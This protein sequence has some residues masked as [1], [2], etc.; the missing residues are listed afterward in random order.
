MHSKFYNLIIW[1]LEF[2]TEYGFFEKVK[3]I[4]G[5]HGTN[6]G[7]AARYLK[8]PFYGC[9]AHLLNLIVTNALEQ[10]K[11]DV[12]DNGHEATTQVLNRLRKL[13]GL[14][15]QSNLLTEKLHG[16]K[17]YCLAYCF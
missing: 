1:I 5:D 12:P 9:F 4:T 7:A 13:V 10:L 3:S 6:I 16:E 17:S 14:F 15:N 11:I 8:I 2:C